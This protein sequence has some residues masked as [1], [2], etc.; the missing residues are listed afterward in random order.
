MKLQ[1]ITK[2][3]WPY[4]EE[5]RGGIGGGEEVRGGGGEEGRGEEEPVLHNV[6][7]I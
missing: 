3:L 7:I 4:G 2:R 5:G 1:A 6:A